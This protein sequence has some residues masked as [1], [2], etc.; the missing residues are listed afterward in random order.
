M[1]DIC[2]GKK[3]N[4]AAMELISYISSIVRSSNGSK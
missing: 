1:L 2:Y 4:K 3:P